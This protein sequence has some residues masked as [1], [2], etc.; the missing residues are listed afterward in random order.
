MQACLAS[1]DVQ[2]RMVFVPETLLDRLLQT[3]ASFLSGDQLRAVSMRDV[4]DCLQPT[5]AAKF[6]HMELPK[7]VAVRLRMIESLPGWRAI[8]EFVQTYDKMQNWYRDMR[9]VQR[10]DKVGLK[11][12]LTAIKRIR[13]ESNYM[14]PAVVE[15]M[16]KLHSSATTD[17]TDDFVNTWLDDFFMIRIG[18]NMLVDQC[19][20]IARLE[21]GGLGKPTGIVDTNCDA[22]LVCQ[23]AAEY[24][25]ALCRAHLG[26]APT[27]IIETYSA[28]EPGAQTSN[29]QKFSYIPTYLRYIMIELLKN[30]FKATV[31]SF[32]NEAELSNRP[33][34]ILVCSDEN[35][36]AIRVSDQ[37]NGIPFHVGKRIWSYLYGAATRDGAAPVPT[38]LA[39][40]GVGLPISRLHAR[41]LGGTLRVASFPGFGTDTFLHLPIIEANQVEDL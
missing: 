37:A 8:P 11:E 33:V 10:S 4:L 15:G 13:G 21:D 12:F 29:H 14:V 19:I 27:Y 39:G 36:C 41:Y 1:S 26:H 38:P 9:L 5:R 2:D 16:H 22:T 18:S 40:W 28:D 20:A 17:F 3:E 25:K 35:H 6:I 34:R 30:S 23:Q 24:A 7:R 31:E 32:P